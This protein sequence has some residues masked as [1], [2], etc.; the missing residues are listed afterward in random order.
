MASALGIGS[1]A[2]TVWMLASLRMG[3]SWRRA[4]GWTPG[5]LVRLAPDRLSL[6]LRL[7]LPS[8]PC[9]VG[10]RAEPSPP[11][12]A[13]GTAAGP[14]DRRPCHNWRPEAEERGTENVCMDRGGR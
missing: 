4:S 3:T 8:D 10:L 1:T 7:S 11:G 2:F 5:V 9:P 6:G 14:E 12:L 13:V